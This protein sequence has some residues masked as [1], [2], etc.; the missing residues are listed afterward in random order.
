M[1]EEPADKLTVMQRHDLLSIISIV[2]IVEPDFV[3][4][5]VDDALIANRYSMRVSGQI[6]DDAVGS[7]LAAF[8][9]HHPVFLHQGI[10]DFIDLIFVGHTTE[11]TL[12][13][14]LAQCTDE[15]APVVAR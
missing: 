3:V 5:N 8:A 9:V 10:K 6:A 12:G 13:G 11:L 7:F 15:V 4:L 2:L 14:T 1:Q